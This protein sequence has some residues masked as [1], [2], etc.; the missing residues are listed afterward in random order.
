MPTYYGVLPGYEG[1]S[2]EIEAPDKR[3]GRT[4]FLDFLARNR[5]IPYGQRH[6]ARRR[7]KLDNMQPGEIPTTVRLSYG[8]DIPQ[9]SSEI[10]ESVPHV[11]GDLADE[12]TYGDLGPYTSEDQILSD[13]PDEDNYIP[14]DRGSLSPLVKAPVSHARFDGQSMVNIPSEVNSPIMQLSKV[15]GGK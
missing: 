3:H 12:P 6:E 7:V 11:S 8:G 4:V 9:L 1:V 10:V 13:A 15:S 14:E 5:I 2:A